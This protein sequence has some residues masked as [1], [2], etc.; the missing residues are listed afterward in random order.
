MLVFCWL[1]PELPWRI[2]IDPTKSDSQDR[3]AF[4]SACR[5]WVEWVQPLTYLV[6][7]VC[8]HSSNGVIDIPFASMRY[9]GFFPNN[10]HSTGQSY[11]QAEN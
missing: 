4:S 6:F 1:T 5:P 11:A 2:R 8:L 10:H 3:V 9:P 7:H